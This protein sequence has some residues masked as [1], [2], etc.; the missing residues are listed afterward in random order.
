MITH[1]ADGDEY[2]LYT[3]FSLQDAAVHKHGTR[4]QLEQAKRKREVKRAR[5][6]ARLRFNGGY[7]VRTRHLG[8]ERLAG[9]RAVKT[10][11]AANCGVMTIKTATALL[12]G[13]GSMMSEAVHSA[14]DVMNQALLAIG[15]HKGNK[16][17]TQRNPYGFGHELYAFSMLA[18]VGTF[19]LGSG[20]ALYHGTDQLLHPHALE[21]PMVA[22]AVL[23]AAGLLEGFTLKVACEEIQREASKLNLSF[24]KYLTDGPDPINTAVFLEDSVAVGGVTVAGEPE[25]PAWSSF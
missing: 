7:D 9:S 14:V 1:D 5:R 25:E 22:L 19:F 10:A 11:M 8:G 24:R 17:A 18:G 16:E 21:Y 23:G 15:L 20:V 4:E 6:V 3:R 12:T 13:S 2:S